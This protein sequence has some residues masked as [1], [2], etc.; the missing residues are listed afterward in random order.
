MEGKVQEKLLELSNARSKV[1]TRVL[2]GAGPY[3]AWLESNALLHTTLFFTTLMIVV[4][5]FSQ[6]R[7]LSLFAFHPIFMT[8]G[9][10]CFFA[11]GIV[12]YKNNSLL[13]IFGP[14]MQHNRRI[15]VRVIHQSLQ[16]MGSACIGMGLLFIFANKGMQKKSILPQT[17]HSLFGTVAII[18]IVVQGV[19]GMQK[20]SQIESKSGV[21][22]R[23]WHGDSGLLLWDFLC[24]TMMLGML[25]F[26]NFTLTNLLVEICVVGAWL[27]VHAQMR[28][29]GDQAD[30][31][32]NT[33]LVEQEI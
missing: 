29:K 21:K 15:K 27:L 5:I 32:S 26:L 2:A 23:R 33:E 18:L 3:A 31:E 22:I 24:V 16:M 4:A 20:M 10:L 11:Q 19:S 7:A 28:R 13:D 12:A 17:L 30:G 14:I 8:I 9:T 1:V 6:L 25:E